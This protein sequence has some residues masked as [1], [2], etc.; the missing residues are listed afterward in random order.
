MKQRLLWLALVAG[1]LLATLFL[2]ASATAANTTTGFTTLV[3]Q[4]ETVQ[5]Y[6]DQFGIPHIW[7][8][9]NRG[10]FEA[11]GY[12]VAQDRLWQLELNRRA[13]RGTLAEIF[14]ASQVNAD[15]YARTVGYTDAE[16]DRQYAALPSE[17]Q[18]IFQAYTDGINR[19]LTQVVAPDPLT[20]LPF[21]FHALGITPA[22]WTLR[23]SVA[24]GAFMVRRFGE[25]GGRE[26]T[27]QAFLNSL[28]AQHGQQAAY[29][30]FND[31]RWINDPDAPITVPTSG[32]I[33]SLRGKTEADTSL[34]SAPP[35]VDI[36]PSEWERVVQDA[37]QSWEALGVPT[38][39]GSY[40]WVVSP[41]KSANGH[42]MLYGGPQ[43][44][45]STPEVLHLVQLTGGN[46]FNVTG[47]AFAGAPPVLIGRNEQIAWTSTTATGDNLDHYVET[48]CDAGAG[49][50]SGYL[51]KGVCTAYEQRVEL[52]NVRG[53][54]AVTL[55]VLR[56]V[57]GP[58]VSVSGSV[59]VSQKRAHWQREVQAITPF[60][61]FDRAKSV[62]EFEVAAR[63]II[64]SH[65]FLY[66]DNSGNIAY[67]QAGQP[68]IRPQGF[69][70]RLPFPGDGSAEWPGGV[71]PMPRSINPTQGWLA[72][73]NNKPSVDYP[74]PDD[75]NQGKQNRLLD[76][77][78]RLSAG[79]VSL[80]D[81]HDIPKDIA[82]VK[83]LGRE[84]R[85]LKPYLLAALDAVPPI[86]PLAAQAHAALQ[87][88]D[89]SAIADA[90]TSTTTLPGEVIFSTW[91]DRM[92][93]NT[94]ADELGSRLNEASSNMLLHVLDYALTG[95]SGV[96]PS[97]DYFNGLPP[98]AVMSASF[99][100]AV[101][102]LAG[103]LGTDVTTWATA[104]GETVFTHP[105]LGRVASIPQSNRSTYGQIVVMGMNH[106]PGGGYDNPGWRQTTDE[107][108]FTLG[109]SSFVQLVPPTGFAL[110]PHYKDL[111]DIYR[112]FEYIPMRLFLGLPA[113]ASGAYSGQLTPSA[114]GG[115]GGSVHV[116]RAVN[117]DYQVTVTV[118]GLQ[119]GS[120]HAMHFHRGSCA[121]QGP[122][123][124]PLP[125][126]VANGV[127][128]AT[129]RAWLSASQ[130]ATIANGPTYLNIHAQLN[131]PGDGIT[132]A[133][134]Q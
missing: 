102:L 106:E 16:L 13:A 80:A 82:R 53:A 12:A 22:P 110:D 113:R 132:C 39:L 48:L 68:P 122:V 83:A 2:P 133:D 73:W 6:R 123:I 94:F 55:P 35:A 109:Q 96:R 58:V 10:L 29:G 98:L 24:F 104:R 115:P 65:N 64:T 114:S 134:I 93:A 41:G 27:N 15:R 23:D 72:N 76:L 28:I 116:V 5:I 30:I 56:S 47:M 33:G 128:I 18:G 111:N 100:Q 88:W 25:I 7:A 44:G 34:E 92:L 31:A 26:L 99:D 40:G 101:A 43:M 37:R 91:L 45:F 75:Q 71:L 57:H 11:Y 125:P 9:T 20:K 103:Q 97:R 74:N 87:A 49:A 130:W 54:S 78:A 107:T 14:G 42:A 4:G 52:I 119:P 121:V 19:Y 63:Q 59:A 38:K 126:I 51:Y 8:A 86:H 81:M 69:D 50:G 95:T 127:G 46:G 129:V 61:T 120:S 89:G 118:Y 117:G 21:E 32:A 105:I 108:I 79:P 84:A 90:V 85:T 70:P 36:D 124:Q 17:V 77:A 131:P 60:L 67:W 66:A 3:V 112:R 1:A 62:G